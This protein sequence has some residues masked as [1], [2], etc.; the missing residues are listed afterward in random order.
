MIVCALA[1]N[2]QSKRVRLA[3]EYVLAPKEPERGLEPLATQLQI[4]CS[5]N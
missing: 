2:G 4:E 3:A 1:A 5:T